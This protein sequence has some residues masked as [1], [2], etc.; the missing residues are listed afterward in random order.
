MPS[1]SL[2]FLYCSY[3]AQPSGR[4][5]AARDDDGRAR[6]GEEC[7][8]LLCKR[9]R[10]R[11]HVVEDDEGSEARLRRLVITQSSSGA[12]RRD[13]EFGSQLLCVSLGGSQLGACDHD[14]PPSARARNLLRSVR[15]PHSWRS[16]DHHDATCAHGRACLRP[17]GRVTHHA[18]RAGAQKRRV[19]GI[20]DR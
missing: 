7:G 13:G 15:L 10:Q 4:R 5:A 3:T 18:K 17:R 8:H 16:S 6:C 12:R 20:L 11:V 9:G 19:C 14:A 2:S 1:S